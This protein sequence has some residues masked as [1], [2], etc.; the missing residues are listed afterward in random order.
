MTKRE[1]LVGGVV[2]IGAASAPM[3]DPRGVAVLRTETAGL[4]F[5]DRRIPESAAF[6]NAQ[7]AAGAMLI[8]VAEEEAK[9]WRGVRAGGDS[10]ARVIGLTRWSEWIILRDAFQQQ[11]KRIRREERVEPRAAAHQALFGWEMR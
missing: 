1:T 4:A 6:A 7:R 11:G 9:L 5:Y 2:I 3:L 10:R 8:D